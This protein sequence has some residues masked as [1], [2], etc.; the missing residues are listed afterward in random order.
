MAISAEIVDMYGTFSFKNLPLVTEYEL[1][2]SRNDNP[3]NGVTT[4]DIL[5][6]QKHIL[7]V[8]DLSSNYKLIAA[9][10]NQSETV[11][12]S[13]ISEIRRLILGKISH[14]KNSDSWNFVPHAHT[15]TG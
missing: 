2:M 11:T 10:V 8:R 5:H 1:S 13:D 12:A 9:D 4:A 15:F 3:L 14:F 7:G 6:I